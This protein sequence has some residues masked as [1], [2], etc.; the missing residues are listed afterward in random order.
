MLSLGREGVP[1]LGVTHNLKSEGAYSKYCLAL[2]SPNPETQE[3]EYV[4]YLLELGRQLKEKAVL[5]ATSDTAALLLCKMK[6]ILE[7]YFIFPISPHAIVE[8]LGRKE[9]FSSELKRCGFPHPKTYTPDEL[10]S[11]A[12]IGEDVGFPCIIKPLDC[13]K[14]SR[15]YQKKA[16]PA[17][18]LEELIRICDMVARDGHDVI[19]Q[20]MIPGPDNQLHLVHAYFN[21]SSE[22]LGIFTFRRIRA[23]PLEFGTGSMCVAIWIPSLASQVKEFIKQI[24]YHGIIDAELKLDPRDNQ[25]KFI[26]INPRPAWQIRLSTRCGVNVPYLAYRDAIGEKVSK[27]TPTLNEV[28]WIAMHYDMKASYEAM[29]LKQLTIRE[30]MRS[31]VGGI[32]WAVFA[33]DDPLPFLFV[34]KKVT[35]AGLSKV[36]RLVFRPGQASSKQL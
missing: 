32:E 13:A 7:P 11:L 5:Y 22:T 3:H 18:N 26:E 27:Q 15:Q 31:L 12:E 35:Y 10:G 20:E 29:K 6:D 9:R 23:Y 21:A 30:Y 8:I 25:F 34:M 4:E 19:I 24:G 1:V 33:W 16:I 2:E 28:K 36:L 14:F 17:N